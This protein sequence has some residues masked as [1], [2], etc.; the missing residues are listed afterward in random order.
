VAVAVHHIAVAAVAVGHTEVAV[1]QGRRVAVVV[2]RSY[3]DSSL[4]AATRSRILID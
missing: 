1:A 2:Y 3:Q 4:I